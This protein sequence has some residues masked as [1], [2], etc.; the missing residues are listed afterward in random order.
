MEPSVFANLAD[1]ENR[2][3]VCYQRRSLLDSALPLKKKMSRRLY[4][5]SADFYFICV[6]KASN[7]I[8]VVDSNLEGTM[9][10]FHET[11]W[12][13]VS[14][15]LIAAQSILKEFA[16][17]NTAVSLEAYFAENYASLTSTLMEHTW[18][19]VQ[20]SLKRSGVTEII[21]GDD[22]HISADAPKL[23]EGGQK[24]RLR[25]VV[26]AQLFFFLKDIV[27]RHQHHDPST[28]TILD[29][30]RVNKN[31]TIDDVT[32]RRETLRLLYRAVLRYKRAK[33]ET[34]FSS[35]R[36]T[37]AYIRSFKDIYE[38]EVPAEGSNAE[39]RPKLFPEMNDELMRESIMSSQMAVRNSNEERAMEQE[40]VRNII[41]GTIGIVVS[42]LGLLQLTDFRINEN[43]LHW[44]LSFAAKLFLTSPLIAIAAIF[45]GVYISLI[46]A[47][48]KKPW[49]S[50]IV[51]DTLRLFH[52]RNRK[53]LILLSFAIGAIIFFAAAFFAFYSTSNNTKVIVGGKDNDAAVRTYDVIHT[54]KGSTFMVF[55]NGVS[56]TAV[57]KTLP[58]DHVSN[59][60]CNP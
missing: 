21:V 54:P 18:F 7:S 34:V 5:L 12:P 32:W 15:H 2:Y 8:H 36:G 60:H 16:R 24:E 39:S 41:L 17:Q 37:L 1:T 22:Q 3:L 42:I 4:D 19:C 20:F 35:A 46:I 47:G 57:N 13:K 43:E 14:G 40:K 31:G 50:A 10:I 29:V 33:T 11:N 56:C 26:C 9:Y 30:Y 58:K 51:R 44:L 49:E 6:A 25:H 45:C 27:H 38:K 53:P 55:D 59:S 52:S 28:D 48:V 23:P